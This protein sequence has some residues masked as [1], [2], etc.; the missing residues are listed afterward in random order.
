MEDF[1]PHSLGQITDVHLRDMAVKACQN[2]IWPSRRGW[3]V[4]QD[5]TEGIA[6]EATA[7][8]CGKGRSG[9]PSIAVGTRTAPRPPHRSQRAELPHWAPTLGK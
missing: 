1:W 3:A 5:Q 2:L 8:F 6:L 7:G 9:G 4:D